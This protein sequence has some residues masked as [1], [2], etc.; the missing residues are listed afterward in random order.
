M[1]E[2]RRPLLT[3][4]TSSAKISKGEGQGWRNLILYLAPADLVSG[5]QVCPAAS[6]GCKAACLYTAGRGQMS[7]VQQARVR[8]TE[9][10]RDNEAGFVAQLVDEIDRAHRAARR[11]GERLAVR[12]NG[13]SDLDWESII[14]R[15]H[16]YFYEERADVV[17]YEYTKRPQLAVRR[18]PVHYTFSASESNHAMVGRM[19]RAGVNVAMVFDTARGEALPD[20][21]QGY[22]VLDGDVT[23][24][25]YL[26]PRE[27]SSGW[28]IGLRA[29]G[30]A[31]R[32]TSG[33]VQN[34]FEYLPAVAG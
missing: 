7:S 24:Q 32:D 29:K 20:I 6:A 26:D 25:R 30:Q 15:Y 13:T 19:L 2:K 1:S 10:L 28:I 5:M 12:L 17:F 8:R 9:Y 18:G 16:P 21:W 3:K 33:F 14:R 22:R 4:G 31:R 34:Q 23:D 27:E 11:A